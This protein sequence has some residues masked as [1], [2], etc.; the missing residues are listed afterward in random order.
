MNSCWRNQVRERTRVDFN[1]C[2]YCFVLTDW[3]II[4]VAVINV[5][6]CVCAQ[7][8]QA[9]KLKADNIRVALEK[10]K[11]AQVK[12]VSQVHTHKKRGLRHMCRKC[13]C[14]CVCALARVQ[15]FSGSGQCYSTLKAPVNNSWS[16]HTQ[17]HTHART[18]STTQL[19]DYHKLSPNPREGG[20]EGW[21]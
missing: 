5:C 19:N 2:P 6:V 3:C 4:S 7:E 15:W 8:E 21:D 9:A 14:M 1:V 20:R 11:E 12:K 13:V 10:I 18:H 17:T 16:Q